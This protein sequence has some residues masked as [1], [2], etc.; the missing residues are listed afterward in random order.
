ML[1]SHLHAFV[2]HLLAKLPFQSF[3]SR[4]TPIYP[5]SITPKSLLMTIVIFILNSEMVLKS[6]LFLL[7]NADIVLIYRDVYQ[8]RYMMIDI[9]LYIYKLIYIYIY[10]TPHHFQNS[11]LESHLL[12]YIFI[13]KYPENTLML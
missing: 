8:D 13:S 10:R 1:I 12:A 5:S 11:S 9:M 4:P 2:E 3:F 6:L 7:N